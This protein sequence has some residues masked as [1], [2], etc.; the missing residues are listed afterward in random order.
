MI[1]FFFA[2]LCLYGILHHQSYFYDLLAEVVN[3]KGRAD[4]DT[5]LI[6]ECCALITSCSG[7][8]R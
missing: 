8:G 2:N 1:R 4:V 6:I 7:Q 5:P 3:K